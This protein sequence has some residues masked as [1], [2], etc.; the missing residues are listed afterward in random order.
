MSPKQKNDVP[1]NW[2]SDDNRGLRWVMPQPEEEKSTKPVRNKTA[3]TK[4]SRQKPSSPKRGSS[5]EEEERSRLLTMPSLEKWRKYWTE[6]GQQS[7]GGWFLRH[8]S[9]FVSEAEL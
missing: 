3:T 1:S 5:I 8:V 4:T 7:C 2:T 6:D 9:G